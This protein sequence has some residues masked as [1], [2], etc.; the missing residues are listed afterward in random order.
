M[1]T[2]IVIGATGLIGKALTNELIKSDK[3]SNIILLVRKVSGIQHPKIKELIFNYDHPDASLLKG[4]D[5]FCSLG[6]TIKTAGSQEAFKKVDLDYV[7]TIAKLAYQNGIAQIGVVSA[8]GADAGSGIFYNRVKGRM[9]E[10]LKTIGFKT[11]FVFRPS[12]LLGN[13]QEFRLGES[14]GKFLMQVL[15]AFIP[16]KYKAIQDSQVAQAMIKSLN[17]NSTGFHII[18]NDRMLN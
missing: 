7:I 3:Y 15:S 4:D 17:S 1:K 18:E 8:I 16:K 10:Q 9:E 14:I 11:C 13:R 5:L 12:M 6:T 2:A